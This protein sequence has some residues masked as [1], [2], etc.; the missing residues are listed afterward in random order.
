LPELL[1]LKANIS[2]ALGADSRAV[3]VLLRESLGLSERQDSRAWSLR[4]AIDLAKLW[5]KQGRISDAVSLVQGYRES[6]TEGFDTKDVRALEA[7]WSD[8]A[9]SAMDSA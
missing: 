6:V 3:E 2:A 9:T 1:R 4:T 8:M 5:L 7:L